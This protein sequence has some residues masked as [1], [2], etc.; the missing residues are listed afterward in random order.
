M[1]SD[2]FRGL[3]IKMK[4]KEDVFVHCHCGETVYIEKHKAICK[5]CKCVVLKDG[6]T[7]ERSG[8]SCRKR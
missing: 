6:T 3:Q 5:R 4:V 7:Y 8:Y 1:E 2:R